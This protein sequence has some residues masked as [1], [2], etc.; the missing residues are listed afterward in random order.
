MT[1]SG[2]EP[3]RRGAFSSGLALAGAAAAFCILV[4]LGM[5]QVQRL[6]WKEALIATISERVASEPRPLAEIERR[7]LETRDVDYWPVRASGTFMH[8]QEQFFFA[9]YQGQSGWFV[10]TPLR[11]SDGRAVFVNRG[12]VPYDRKD[13]ATRQAGQAAGEVTVE[14]LARNPLAEKPSF[15]LPDNDPAKNIYY[16]KDLAALAAAAGLGESVLPF[17]IDA[18][19]TSDPGALP[20][21]GVTILDL[22]N[23]HL[24]Y[25][26]TWFGLAAALLAVCVAWFLRRRG[27]VA[28]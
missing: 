6:A 28:G 17:F 5:W 24:Q 15:L 25:A 13:A 12:F 19:P 18:G 23:N 26:V 10:Y 3:R 9:T 11:L 2:H 20:R 8:E 21:G 16:W 4:A 1:I 22:P 7:F 14:G 27:P